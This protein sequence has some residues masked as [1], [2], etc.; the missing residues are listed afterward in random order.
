MK[1]TEVP[2]SVGP[3]EHLAEDLISSKGDAVPVFRQDPVDDA[4]PLQTYQL[5][6]GLKDRTIAGDFLLLQPP[7]DTCIRGPLGVSWS[8]FALVA[9]SS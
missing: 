1:L 4:I 7:Q 5:L 3:V 9:S 6:I 8:S 2:Q